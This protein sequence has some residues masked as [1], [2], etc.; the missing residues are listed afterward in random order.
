MW[1]Y[2]L[3]EKEVTKEE[4]FL[5]VEK[6]KADEGNFVSFENDNGDSLQIVKLDKNSYLIDIPQI[7]NKIVQTIVKKEKLIEILETFSQN[8]NWKNLC[9]WEEKFV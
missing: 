1:H 2:K 7:S 6:L 5:Y 9:D 3:P 4:L 8:G